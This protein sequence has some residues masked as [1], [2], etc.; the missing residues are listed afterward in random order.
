MVRVFGT[1]GREY[2]PGSVPIDYD[3]QREVLSDGRALRVFFPQLDSIVYVD[4]WSRRL[5]G[6]DMAERRQ[7]GEIVLYGRSA[8]AHVQFIEALRAEGAREAASDYLDSLREYYPGDS[9]LRAE[10]PAPG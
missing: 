6:F 7:T 9:L 4:R 5:R 10:L 2:T 1:R 3:L 8:S